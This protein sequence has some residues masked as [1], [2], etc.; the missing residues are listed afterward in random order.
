MMVKWFEELSQYDF[1]VVHVRG[2]KNIVA[3]GLSRMM[4]PLSFNN[5]AVEHLVRD[6]SPP[7]SEEHKLDLV[8]K[9]HAFGHFGEQEIFRKLWNDGWWWS[10][11]RQDIKSEISG[12]VPCLRY[13]VLRRG[14]H[15]L[16]TITAALPWDHIAIDLVTPLP[17]SDDGMDTLLV[18]VDIMTRFVILRC[19]TS[20][21][22]SQIARHMW[23]VFSI[24]GVPKIIQSDNGSEFVNE[25]IEELVNLNGIDHRTISAYNPRANGAVERMNATVENVLRKMVDGAMHV[26]P[27]YIPFVQLSCNAKTSSLTGAT[28]F[29]LMFGRGLNSFE[30]Y[31]RSTKKTGDSLVLW[32]KRQETLAKEVYPSV[33]ERIDNSKKKMA[34]SYAKNKHMVSEERFLPGTQVMMHD[35]TKKS[36]WDPVYEGPFSIVRKN[37]G[38]A[39]VLRD[40][41]GETLKRTVP[42]DQLKLIM[43]KNGDPAIE[44]DSFKVDKITKHRTAKGGKFEYYVVW[45]DKSIEPGWEPVEN[46]DDISCIKQYW[47]SIRP[48]RRKRRTR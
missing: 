24:F 17:V 44:A 37:K 6:K 31:G 11:M 38:G 5:M 32:K 43:R 22:M 36:K 2:T 3:D 46:F 28:P 42:P 12:C 35:A 23:E 30:E 1:N 16:K 15:P 34:D 13:N 7:D 4:E 18:V 40:R 39:Y 45:K 19:L 26:W 48:T 29:A 8:K 27:D 10:K 33:H 25:L 21:E 14:Y 9:A 47:N 20:K 41:L